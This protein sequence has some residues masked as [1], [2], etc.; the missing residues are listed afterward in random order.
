MNPFAEILSIIIDIYVD[1]ILLRFFL[2]YFRADFY[3]PLSQFIV[4]ATD[5]IVKPLRKLI[6]GIGGLDMS[7]LVAAWL[8]TIGKIL[9]VSLLSTSFSDFNP[10]M[11]AILP[12]YMVLI[13]CIKLYLFLIFVSA[14]SSWFVQGG[15]N[16]VLAVIRQL[17]DPLLNK[18]R[19][20][21][22]ASGGGF[23]FTPMIAILGLFL[24]LRILDYYVLPS[25][26]Q[27][28]G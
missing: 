20:L 21:I 5:P 1:I 6:P 17:T 25:I 26:R 8:I 16:P 28:I 24:L 2:Q 13:E 4:K 23:D 15:Y 11:L 18:C 27:L 7:T 10:T 9:L 14:I 3:N 12:I 19:K 22:P